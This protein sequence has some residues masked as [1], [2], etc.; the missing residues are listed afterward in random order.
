MSASELA[1]SKN[2]FFSQT[3]PQIFTGE[4]STKIQCFWCGIVTCGVKTII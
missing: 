4:H 1:I 2:N 3:F